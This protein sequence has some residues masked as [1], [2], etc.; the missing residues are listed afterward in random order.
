MARW[1]ELTGNA[2]GETVPMMTI[3][4]LGKAWYADRLS[5]DFRGLDP[6]RVRRIFDQVGLTSDFWRVSS[7]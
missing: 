3:W 1:V 2:S 5:P 4:E 7:E 6:A